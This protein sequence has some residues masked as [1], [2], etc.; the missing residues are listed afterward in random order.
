MRFENAKTEFMYFETGIGC[1]LTK[2]LK[3]GHS[4]DIGVSTSY[5]TTR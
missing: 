1:E 2:L 4:Q 3:L 5:N